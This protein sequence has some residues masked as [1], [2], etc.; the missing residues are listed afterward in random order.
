[1]CDPV[2]GLFPAKPRD[3]VKGVNFHTVA[4]TPDPVT[5][6]GPRYR[7]TRAADVGDRSCV[8]CSQPHIL[9]QCMLFAGMQPIERVHVATRHKLWYNC[10]LAGHVSNTCYKQSMCTVPNCS[11][12]HSELL[13][14]DTVY[15]DNVVHDNVNDNI[16][17][18]NIF[19]Q[20]EGASVYLPIVPVIVNGSSRPIYALLDSGSASS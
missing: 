19:T 13:H 10:L 12:K 5:S 16:Q 11:R 18:C 6:S 15:A 4:V 14:T 20:R 2:Y 17:V 9:S 7:P 8:V 1:M 3:D